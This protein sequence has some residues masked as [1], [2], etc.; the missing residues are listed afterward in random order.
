[1][2]KK[3]KKKDIYR[4]NY[5]STQSRFMQNKNEIKQNK[6]RKG[7]KARSMKLS[8]IKNGPEWAQSCII[9]TNGTD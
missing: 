2:K 7:G 3:K 9:I 6:N 8:G 5:A 4:I 1:M